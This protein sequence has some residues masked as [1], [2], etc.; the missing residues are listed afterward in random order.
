MDVKVRS[1]RRHSKKYIF[2]LNIKNLNIKNGLQLSK[3]KQQCLS[4][5]YAGVKF[6]VQP[7]V[8]NNK[9]I[10]NNDISPELRLFN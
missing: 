5:I 7:F 9:T 8:F 1:H 10:M 6:M 2:G 3:E 4:D